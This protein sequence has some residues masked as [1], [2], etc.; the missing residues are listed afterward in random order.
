MLIKAHQ[1]FVTNAVSLPTGQ[2]VSAASHPGGAW[3]GEGRCDGPGSAGSAS[4]Q[5]HAALRRLTCV[6]NVTCPER[7]VQTC[8]HPV[9]SFSPDRTHVPIG[10]D[11]RAQHGRGPS[12]NFL[13]LSD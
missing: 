4:I 7:H 9:V 8:R 2:A 3:P 10:R 6:L 13:L 11:Q 5:A 12:R 1:S